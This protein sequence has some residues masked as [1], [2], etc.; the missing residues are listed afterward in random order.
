MRNAF[1]AGLLVLG[2]AALCLIALA[3][4]D[5]GYAG[6]LTGQTIYAKALTDHECSS[7]EWEFVITQID[8][9]AH[10]PDSISVTWANGQTATVPVK[11]FSG[12]KLTGGTAHYVTTANLDSTVVSASTTIYSG[13]SGEFN[14]SHG[15]C[16]NTPTPT[17][18]STAT[19][20][21]TVTPTPTSTA[22]ATPTSTG[23][24]VT[25]T[26]TATSTPTETASPTATPTSGGGGGE[27]TN[28]PTPT[29]AG[30]PPTATPTSP[31]PGVPER[32][33][34]ASATPI[35]TE[36][37]QVAGVAAAV[38]PTQT[39]APPAAPATET[40]VP[41]A[42]Q[43]TET[44][45]PPTETPEVLGIAPP[46]PPEVAGVR[47]LPS[48]GEADDGQGNVALLLVLAGLL[49]S[50]GGMVLRRSAR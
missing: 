18:T 45:V 7:S 16:G 25:A 13:W 12:K 4:T 2:A 23:T 5:V 22:T 38:P 6:V 32:G 35:P 50:S 27:A 30:T 14:L 41:A 21:P 49:A 1:Y 11:L 17:A 31:P 26:P 40:P 39:P 36:T 42:A 28:T 46:P 47:A 9:E 48:A 29:A 33:P 34:A 24:V 20:T 15:P 37:P 43:A 19:S 10:A 44:P 3:P 8:T